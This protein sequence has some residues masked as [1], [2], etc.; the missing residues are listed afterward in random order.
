[1][2][3]YQNGYFI[4]MFFWN[5]KF[6]VIDKNFC[7]RGGNVTGMFSYGSPHQRDT[8][9]HPR[10]G[11]I[12]YGELPPSYKLPSCELSS[13]H[14]HVRRTLELFKVSFD[15]LLLSIDLNRFSGG[16][17]VETNVLR[18]F[19]QFKCVIN[20]GI[21]RS[22]ASS[23]KYP[24]LSLIIVFRDLSEWLVKILIRNLYLCAKLLHSYSAMQKK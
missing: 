13:G 5:L 4:S 15:L 12:P 9:K 11:S 23:D 16:E 22:A 8:T 21:S 14:S 1:M 10:Y 2:Y 20:F 24:Y 3:N 17:N 7:K 6:L 19:P 18:L